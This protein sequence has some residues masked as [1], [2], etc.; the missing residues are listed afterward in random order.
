MRLKAAAEEAENEADELEKKY[1][2]GELPVDRFVE[3][4]TSAKVKYHSRDMKY[5]AA[6]QTIPTAQSL[7]Q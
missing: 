4:Y 1:K 7:R 6:L 2:N 5:Q 3:E